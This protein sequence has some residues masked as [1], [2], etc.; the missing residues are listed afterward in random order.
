M[1]YEC[2]VVG[3]RCVGYIGYVVARFLTDGLNRKEMKHLSADS[4]EIASHLAA[5]ANIPVWMGRGRPQSIA[6]QDML[7]APRSLLQQAAQCLFILY[8]PP[9]YRDPERE[10]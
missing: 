2:G 7:L 1:I 3:C 5:I 10:E 8:D 4:S 6:D 9:Q